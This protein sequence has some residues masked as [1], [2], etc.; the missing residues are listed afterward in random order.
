MLQVNDGRSRSIDWKILWLQNEKEQ[1]IN[2]LARF[3]SFVYEQKLAAEE[4][5]LIENI[6]PGGMDTAGT[7]E[8]QCLVSCGSLPS[9]K[10]N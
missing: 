2:N 5:A 10:L 9:E 1:D 7:D 6:R 3:S 4:K 8:Q